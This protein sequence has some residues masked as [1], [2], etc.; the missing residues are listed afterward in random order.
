M[1]RKQKYTRAKA[2][3]EGLSQIEELERQIRKDKRLVWAS[4]AWSAGVPTIR[5][6]S[7][8][9]DAKIDRFI[10]N[11]KKEFEK[12]FDDIYEKNIISEDLDISRIIYVA[13]DVLYEG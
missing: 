3:K 11:L 12:T 4:Q 13:I 5:T 9:D 10:K 7:F 6:L 1:Q 2:R 8:E